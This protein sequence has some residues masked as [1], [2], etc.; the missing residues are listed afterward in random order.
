M[1]GKVFDSNITIRN[2][3]NQYLYVEYRQALDCSK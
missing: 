1:K 2:F 3:K